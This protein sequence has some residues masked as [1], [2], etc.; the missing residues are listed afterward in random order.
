MK[1]ILTL[2]LLNL[3]FSLAFAQPP[4][5]YYNGT[6]GL[7]GSALKTALKNI[8]TNGH[9]DQ[10]YS[11][12]WTA[13][14]TTDRDY[15]Y[16]NDGTVL[17][18]YSERPTSADQ[19]N[20]T[21][22]SDQCGNVGPEGTCY[23]REHFVPQS[24]FGSSAPMVSDVHF[25]RP[26][27]G[28]V[29]G[30]RSNYPFGKVGTAS[31]TTSNG[32][33]LGNSISTGYSGTV[34]EPIDAFKGDVARMIFYFVTRYENQLSGFSSGDMLGSTAYPGLQPWFLQVL[35]QWNALDPVSPAETA[36][37]NASYTFQGNRNP[38]IDNQ[39]WVNDIWGTPD[40][41]P[42]SAA[43]NLAVTGT[44]ANSAT[45]SWTAATDNVGIGSYDIYVNGVYHSTVSGSLITTT[46]SGLSPSTTYNFYIIAKDMSGNS[47]SQSNTASGTTL[48]GSNPGTGTELYI[49]EYV[50]GSSTNKAIEITNPTSSP[51]DLSA[52]SLQK[53]SNGAGSW[54]NNLQLTGT[55]AAGATYVITN[56]TA[57]FS[58]TFTSNLTAGAPIDFNGNDPVGLFKNGTLIDIVGTLNNTANFAADVTLRRNVVGPST[59]YIAS[60]WDSFPQ[61]TCDNLGIANPNSLGTHEVSLKKENIIYPNPVT[62]GELYVS[63]EQLNKILK[64]EIYS[65]D[66]KLVLSIQN[67]FKNSNKID[68]KK[69]SKGIYI[70]KADFFSDKFIIK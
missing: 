54:V 45:L 48:A 42:P 43:T 11:G 35:L 39:Q 27:D 10:G 61:N 63:G 66:G 29:N 19:Y 49:S 32:S 1:K 47:S 40:S 13:Y 6:S 36:R 34:F 69:L 31:S 17:D 70:L 46:I 8:I 64:A 18:I 38:F 37:N 50:E 5:G 57:A 62:N 59:T 23:N 9:S 16:E 3:M 22:G 30:L 12:L 52:Y 25:I 14:Y 65:L 2:L 56:T 53:Q 21:I 33:K 41:T 44:T 24:L 15:F 68:L 51:I 67:P 4:A 7:T 60:Q 28:H 55:I 58:C 26:T 20:Y